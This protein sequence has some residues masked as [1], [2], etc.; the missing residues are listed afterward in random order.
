MSAGETRQNPTKKRRLCAINAH[1][2]EDFNTVW[3][4]AIVF[5]PPA[6][7]SR[8]QKGFQPASMENPMNKRLAPLGWLALLILTSLLTACASGSSVVGRWQQAEGPNRL[9][10]KPDGTFALSDNTRIAAIGSYAQHADD[11]L[12]YAVTR[13]DPQGT[14]LQPVKTLEVKTARVIIRWNRLELTY[15]RNERPV[16]ETYQ[17]TLGEFS[18]P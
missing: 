2:E 11:T 9:E 4:S 18:L 13:A 7:P 15:L 12:Y 6:K 3:P 5:Q 17:R 10:F 1:F 16:V 8:S 14:G